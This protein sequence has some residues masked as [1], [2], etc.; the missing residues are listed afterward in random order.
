M[1]R[2]AMLAVVSLAILVACYFLYNMFFGMPV[3]HRAI[4]ENDDAPMVAKATSQP[5]RSVGTLME[6]KAAV[7]SGE[8]DEAFFERW[9]RGRLLYQFRSVHWKPADPT[10]TGTYDLEKPELRLFMRGGQIL[11]VSADEGKIEGSQK[12]TKFEPRRGALKGNIHIYLD[13]GTD[14][15]RTAAE[16]RP[17]DIIHIWLNEVRFDLENNRLDT[18]DPINIEADE[19]ALIG[20]GLSITWNNV[21]NQIEEITIRKGEK[22]ILYRGADMLGIKMPGV[23]KDKKAKSQEQA[24][25]DAKLNALAK[26]SAGRSIGTKFMATPLA[27]KKSRIRLPEPVEESTASAPASGPTSKPK[28][29]TS[30]SYKLTFTSDVKINQ[31][32]GEEITGSLVCDRLSVSFDLP[33]GTDSDALTSQPGDKAKD[34]FQKN[35]KRLEIT[36]QGPMEIR[37]EDMGFSEIRRFHILASGQDIHIDQKSQGSVRCKKLTYFEE[38][39]QVWLDGTIEDPVN[40]SQG[41]S[42]TIVAAHLFFDRKQGIATGEGPGFMQ[43]IGSEKSK[44]SVDN[45]SGDMLS[46][47]SLQSDGQKMKVLWNEGFKLTFGEMESESANDVAKEAKTYIKYAEFRGKARMEG[48]GMLMKGDLLVLNFIA[49]KPGEKAESRLDSLRAERDVLLKSEGQEIT[50]E[51]LDVTFADGRNP[52]V[53]HAKGK[54]R[55][56]E[57]RRLIVADE[58]FAK[59]SSEKSEFLAQNMPGQKHVKKTKTRVVIR[60]VEATG[61]VGIRDPEQPLRVNCENLQASFDAQR[62]IQLCNLTGTTKKWASADLPNDY[63]ISGEKIMLNLAS[64]EIDVPGPGKLRFANDQDIEGTKHEKVYINVKWAT[65]MKMSGG[66]KNQGIFLGKTTVRS[67]FTTL[68]CDKMVIDFDNAPA[69]DK[70]VQQAAVPA[71]K[72]IWNLSR[73]TELVQTQKKDEE[74]RL[75]VTRKRPTYIQAWPEEGKKLSIQ[76]AKREKRELLNRSTLWGNELAIDLIGNKINIPGEGVFL[77]ENMQQGKKGG[78]GKPKASQDGN[79]VAPQAPFGDDMK[80]DSPSLTRFTWRNGLT[81]LMDNKTAVFDGAVNMLHVS[82]GNIYDAKTGSFELKDKKP[83]RETSLTCDNLKVEFMKGAFGFSGGNE[84]RSLDLASVVATGSVHL[85]DSPRSVIAPQLTYN[86][87]EKIVVVRGTEGNPAYLYEEKGQTGQYM[88]WEGPIITWDQATDEI[89]AP[90]AAITTTLQ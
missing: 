17:G 39:K 47:S 23:E 88:M 76:Y 52:E 90:G 31:Y 85:Q 26:T 55:A 86:R 65:S 73:F 59:M 22:M 69:E 53:A 67:D 15:K 71:R 9:E 66:S 1:I 58:L 14:P 4:V 44:A 8:G 48:S 20:E 32:D 33:K 84:A 61:N 79:K 18:D 34:K 13:R 36:W 64:E 43:E 7:M 21:T 63:Y 27:V 50:C 54:V 28:V 62:T 70:P 37:P 12:T 56:T 83:E 25:E 5:S 82:G 72:S 30:R 40:I 3:E 10:K 16:M 2:K 68:Y 51:N 77:V 41:E 19:A 42:R 75:P 57:K 49:P 35:G 11:H 38:L 60:E 45:G 87:K 80:S 74:I 78:A 81:Y 89:H 6:P 29:K 46:L 24:E